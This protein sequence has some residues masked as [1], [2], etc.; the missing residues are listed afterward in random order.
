[1]GEKDYLGDLC[2]TAE[3]NDHDSVDE[4]IAGDIVYAKS[5]CAG[6][7]TEEINQ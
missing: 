7:N 6:D 2:P 3:Y 5:L 1:M 4:L